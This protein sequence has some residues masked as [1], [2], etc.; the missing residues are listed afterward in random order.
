M[1]LLVAG[2]SPPFDVNIRLIRS[3]AFGGG[4]ILALAARPDR[5]VAVA[6]PIIDA[7]GRTEAVLF[8]ILSGIT[9]VGAGAGSELIEGGLD[10][11][12][13]GVV[14]CTILVMR[15]N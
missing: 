7:I 14:I 2:R 1:R 15:R 4:M 13:T 8:L 10:G 12:L 11:I 3:V 5:P 6:M 9:I